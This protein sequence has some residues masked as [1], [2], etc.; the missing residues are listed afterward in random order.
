VKAHYRL[1]GITPANVKE[2]KK[3]L[4]ELPFESKLLLGGLCFVWVVLAIYTIY[5]KVKAKKQGS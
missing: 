4:G 5:S 2:G 1:D 3:E